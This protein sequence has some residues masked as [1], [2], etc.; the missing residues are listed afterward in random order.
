MSV[1]FGRWNFDGKPLASDY[2]NKVHAALGPF[3]PDRGGSFLRAGIS[4]IY[5]PFHTN[6]ESRRETQPYLCTSGSVITWDGRIDNRGELTSQ[7]KDDLAADSPDILIVSA[8]YQRWGTACFARL[9][10]DWAVSIWNPADRSLLLAKDPIGVRHL[11]YFLEE[12]QV[13]WSTV[14]DPLVL[15]GGCRLKLDE[16]YLAGWL[17]FFPASHLT[18][19][20]GI[21]SVP[22]SSYVLIETER[23]TVLE[24]WHFD[25]GKRIQYRNDTDYE[26]HFRSVFAQSVRRR[27]HSDMPVLAELSGGL[28]SS[29]IVC[30]A[31]TLAVPGVS[32]TTRLDTVSYYDD[33]EPNWNERP[34]FE[35]VEERRDRVG[36]HINTASRMIPNFDFDN[37]RFSATPD[38]ACHDSGEGEELAAYVISHGNRVLLSG[39]G[40]DEVMG[41]VP[42]PTPELSDL[43]AR[44]RLTGLAQQLKAWALSKRRPWFHLLMEAASEFVPP[45]FLGVPE[46]QRP[47]PWLRADFVR[48]QRSALLGYP[49]RL[50]LFG[51]LPSFQENLN[52]LNVLRRELA[53]TALSSNPPLEK[54]Y[55][56]LDRDLLEYI[57]AI[58][59][60]QLV[61]PGSRR[62]LMRRS[63]RTIVPDEVLNRKRKAFVVR[64]PLAFIRAHWEG[65]IEMN[66]QMICSALGI[67]DSTAFLEALC[68]A[69]RGEEIPIVFLMRTLV[70]ELWLRGLHSPSS[71]IASYL[72][73]QP[74][75]GYSFGASAM[76]AVAPDGTP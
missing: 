71:L 22:A 23:R 10:G 12:R 50:K 16:E 59:R 14:L 33:S 2:V 1:Q 18:P 41:G 40:G 29:S 44:A 69:R 52:T 61:R 38:A 42:T 76:Q 68:R 70:L 45:V 43:L 5:R 58:P 36:C 34:Y 74:A 48:R 51:A 47:S 39:I 7:L 60:Q 64:A 35:S 25:P 73:I 15:L 46:R 28:D 26:E 49:T 62:S 24:Y 75:P 13:T 66:R 37:A 72:G 30:M 63:L 8:A 55:P 53:C 67:V 9:V 4:V 56:F 54:R 32:E 57:Y 21:R 3:A 11:Y 27:M 65:L 20:V 31:D 17:S 6:T 19:Y